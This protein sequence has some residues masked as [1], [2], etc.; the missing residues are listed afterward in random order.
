MDF[1]IIQIKQTQFWTS[2]QSIRVI[3]RLSYAELNERHNGKWFE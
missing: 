2:Q 1:G 3:Q